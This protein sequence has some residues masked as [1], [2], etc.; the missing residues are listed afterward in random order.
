MGKNDEFQLG[1]G[2][3]L[4]RE[5]FVEILRDVAEISVFQNTSYKVPPLNVRALTKDGKLY[6][7]GKGVPSPELIADGVTNLISSTEYRKQDGYVYFITE[8]G[9]E[10]SYYT[11][12]WRFNIVKP[13]ADS[14][15]DNA[16]VIS[17]ETREAIKNTNEIIMPAAGKVVIVSDRNLPSEYESSEE[18]ANDIFN[19][20]MIDDK[21]KVNGILLYFTTED[22]RVWLLLGSGL[23]TP[24]VNQLLSDYFYVEYDK[25]NYDAAI[26]NILPELQK[27]FN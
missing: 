5:S 14:I 17:E 13:L 11:Y 23:K 20:T 10:T 26:Q 2:T 22:N 16:G 6:K 12:V 15:T 9:V 7:W 27:F 21:Q 1:D 19:T 3:A 4:Y 25:G 8:K 24:D 18:Y